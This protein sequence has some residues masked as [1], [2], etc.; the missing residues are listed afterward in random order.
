M[1]KLKKKIEN[2]VEL[3]HW[4]KCKVMNEVD[5]KP[6]SLYT[7]RN[8]IHNSLFRTATVLDFCNNFVDR[9]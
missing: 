3:Y 6:P 1:P 2:E 4:K 8:V 5:C 9:Y 7:Q